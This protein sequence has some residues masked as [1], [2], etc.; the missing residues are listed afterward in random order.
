MAFSRADDRIAEEFEQLL[1]SGGRAVDL[2]DKLMTA[3]RWSEG[4]TFTSSLRARIEHSARLALRQFL[5]EQPSYST[6]H[7]CFT[8]SPEVAN[9]LTVTF[10]DRGRVTIQ[11][12]AEVRRWLHQ[13]QS[14]ITQ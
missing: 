6:L 11:L 5:S 10:D 3:L 4:Q 13:T 9:E 7:D 14:M 8:P 1:L 2:Q 12:P